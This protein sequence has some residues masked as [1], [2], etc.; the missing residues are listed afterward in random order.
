MSLSAYKKFTINNINFYTNKNEGK[1][2]LA[3]VIQA[4]PPDKFVVAQ[5]TNYTRTTDKQK[6]EKN[7]ADMP[8]S[9]KPSLKNF[10]LQTIESMM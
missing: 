3:A 8:W 2:V 4:C 7:I 9:I 1:N 6:T 5:T 10:Y